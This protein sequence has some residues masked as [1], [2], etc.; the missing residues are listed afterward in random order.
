MAAYLGSV[1]VE[2]IGLVY[3]VVRYLFPGRDAS[4]LGLRHDYGTAADL[5][6][7]EVVVHLH[8]FVQ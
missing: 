8:S 1:N 4:A 5:T 6:G 3:V 2:L 7:M